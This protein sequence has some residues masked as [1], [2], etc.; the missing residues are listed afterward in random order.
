MVEAFIES[1]AAL[2]QVLGDMAPYLLLG[3]L[4]A[5]AL[6]VVVILQAWVDESSSPQGLE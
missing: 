6:S 2:W 1:G 3:F 5:G 4:V